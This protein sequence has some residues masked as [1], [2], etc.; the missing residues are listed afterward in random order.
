[1]LSKRRG[2]AQGGGPRAGDDSDETGRSDGQTQIGAAGTAK[3]AR[4]MLRLVR[5]AQPISRAD[6][7][8]RLGINRGA[9]TEVFKPLVASGLVREVALPQD[10]GAGRHMGR[11]ASGLSFNGERGHLVGVSLGVRRSQVGLITLS[12]DCVAED[13]FATPSEPAEAMALIR[14]R[15][16]R[17]RASSVGRPLKMIGVS[18]PGPADARRERLLYAPRLGRRRRSTRRGC[19]C[20]TPLAGRSTTSCWFARVRASAS[21]WFSA[22]RHI[23]AQGPARVWPASSGT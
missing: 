23:A 9:V 17:L 12:G 11:P 16:E 4:L 19:A 22:V 8:R 5:A 20:A 21:A 6:L 2:G 1:L 3:A 15:V 14:S 7:A 18:A 13:E 10:A